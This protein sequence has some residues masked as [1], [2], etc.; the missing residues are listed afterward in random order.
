MI[1][2]RNYP[3]DE[4]SQLVWLCP[5]GG[6]EHHV[7][8]RLRVVLGSLHLRYAGRRA[9]YEKLCCAVALCR[10]YTKSLRR[11]SASSTARRT[12][13]SS[14]PASMPTRVSSRRRAQFK[15][16]SSEDLGFDLLP[17]LPGPGGCC[18]LRC[19]ALADGEVSLVW[20]LLVPRQAEPCVHHRWNPALQ[21]PVRQSAS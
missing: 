15:A 5:G 21:G 20:G 14:P 3:A 6:T 9:V 2:W 13:S 10:I 18:D 4:S 11:P 8:A 19:V 12:P 1:R 16:R 7:F 17:G